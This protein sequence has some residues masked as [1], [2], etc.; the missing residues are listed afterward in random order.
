MLDIKDALPKQKRSNRI[1]VVE[2]VYFQETGVS[3]IAITTRFSRKLHSDEQPCIR[4]IKIGQDW[5]PVE[6]GWVRDCGML[7]INND[8]GKFKTNPSEDQLATV[9]KMIVE[10]A[11]QPP[12]EKNR[13]MHSPPK[14]GPQ[15]FAVIPPQESLRLIP[16]GNLVVRC[17]SGIARI[18]INAFPI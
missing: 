6:M 16:S 9:S 5:L 15:L 17:R 7:V 2:M 4:K 13:N 10:V 11:V 8:E 18:T 3:P 1:A 14:I 12:E